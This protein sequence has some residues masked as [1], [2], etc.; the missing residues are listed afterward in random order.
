MTI[1]DAILL[2]ANNN[3]KH[4][5]VRYNLIKGQC[6]SDNANKV[7]LISLI[8]LINQFVVLDK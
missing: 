4:L 1:T 8:N 5:G 6:F 3:I 2:N 7:I